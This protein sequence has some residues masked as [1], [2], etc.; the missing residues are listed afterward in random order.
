MKLFYYIVFSILMIGSVTI[1]PVH[2]DTESENAALATVVNVLNSLTTIINE[3]QRQQDK[4]TR[5]QF[6]Y[7][8][9]RTDI[10]KIKNGIGERLQ[11][12]TLEPRIILPLNGDYVQLKNN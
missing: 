10:N 2:A 6:Q 12:S 7:D 4:N 1:T 3:A 8:A 9:L 11:S 5:I